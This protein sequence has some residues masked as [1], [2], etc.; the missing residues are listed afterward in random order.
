MTMKIYYQ[1]E[2][3]GEEGRKAEGGIR[4][5]SE[6]YSEQSRQIEIEYE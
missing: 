4:K 6:S 1:E 2:E 5:T 3:E